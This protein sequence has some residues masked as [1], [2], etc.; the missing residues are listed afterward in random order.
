MP[1]FRKRTSP[2]K[3]LA[4][5]IAII[6]GVRT[7]ELHKMLIRELVA[8]HDVEFLKAVKRDDGFALSI[9]TDDGD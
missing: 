1:S 4:A 2:E 7:S 3:R 5:L 6:S 9:E 8:D